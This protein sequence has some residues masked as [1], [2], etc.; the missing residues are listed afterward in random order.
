L[1]AFRRHDVALGP[2]I[3]IT[4]MVADLIRGNAWTALYVLT[5]VERPDGFYQHLCYELTSYYEMHK[6]PADKII[7]M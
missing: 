5:S 6:S 1:L 2:G 4:Q 3:F 7:I